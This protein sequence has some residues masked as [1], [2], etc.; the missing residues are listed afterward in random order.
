M[1]PANNY[2]KFEREWTEHSIPECYARRASAYANRVAVKTIARELTYRD[3]D[4]ISNGVA[5]SILSLR[6]R[7][8]EPVAILLEHDA[9]VPA[10]ILGVLKAGKFYVPLD[11]SYPLERNRFILDDSQ[12]KLV[13]TNS[14]N[15]SLATLLCGDHCQLVNLD[16]IES[17]CAD[18]FPKSQLVADDLVYILY[19]SGST[20]KPKGVMHTHRSLLHNVM[21]Q[22]NGRRICADDRIALLFSYSFGPSAVNTF[23][24]LLNGATLLPFNL[25]E[26]GVTRLA[27]WLT[28]R[29]ITQFHTVPTVFRHFVETLAE[30]QRFPKLR[31][32][33]LGGETIHQKDVALFK[34]HFGDHCI[35]HVGMGTGESGLVLESFYDRWTECNADPIPA[36]YVVEDTQVLLLD[37]QGQPVGPGDI[38]EIA[39]KNRFLSPGYWRNPELTRAVF[40]PDPDG[41]SERIYLTGDQ[42]YMLPDGCVV[43]VGRKDFQVKIRGYRVEIG[44]VEAALLGVTGVKEAVVI[45]WDNPPDDKRLVAYVVLNVESSLTTRA[46]HSSLKKKLPSYMVPSAIMRLESLPLL[47]NGKVDRKAL[48]APDYSR[49]ELDVC[50]IAPRT[51]VEEIV[52]GIWTEVLKVP[53][54]GVEED[55]FELGGHSLLATQVVSRMA[56]AFQINLPLN[57]LFEFP[58]V[59]ALARKVETAL[60]RQADQHL[61]TLCRMPREGHLMLSFGQE[62]LWFLDQ[63]DPGRSVYNVPWVS[64]LRG[65]LNVEAL[66]SALG[67]VV[68]RHEVLRTRYALMEGQP[69]QV[70]EERGCFPLRH[71]DLRDWPEEKREPEVERLVMEEASRAFDLTQ[72]LM[73]RALLIREKE[74]HWVLVLVT[75]HIASDAWSHGI[76][77]RELGQ[78]YDA[79]CQGR[80]AEMEEL[81]IQYTDYA[82]WQRQWLSGEVLEQQLSYWKRQ[83]GEESPVLELPYDRPRRTALGSRGGRVRF[84]L[85]A[86][87]SRQLRDL[88]R[89]EGVT[90]F[91]TLL[92][93]FQVLLYRYTGQTDL[94]LGTPIAGRT[95]RELEGLIGFFVNTLVLRT[96]VEGRLN[97][98]QLLERVREVALGAYS[99]QELP[100][101]RLVQELQPERDL[102][103]NPLF[104]VMFALRN[105]PG[106]RLDL[107]GVEVS[108]LEVEP[109]TAAFDLML[110]VRDGEEQLAGEVDYNAELFDVGTMQRLTGHYRR[111]LE[112]IVAGGVEQEIW[113]LSLL[114]ETE[115][116]QLLVEWNR[117][118]RD[119]PVGNSL[120]ELFEQQ[121]AER[122]ESLAV[123]FKGESW[124][125]RQL[126]ERA[127]R[128]AQHLVELGVGL[129]ERV[130]LCLDRSPWMVAGMIGTLKAGGA[131]VPLDPNYP[132]E[133]L[134]FMLADAQVRVLVTQEHLIEGL[135]LDQVQVVCLDPSWET[136]TQASQANPV[137]RATVRNLAYL[138]YTSGTTGKPKGV[139]N[140]QQGAVNRFQWMWGTYPFEA[141]EICCQKTSLSF[142]DSEWEIFGPLLQGV[143]LILIPDEDVKDTYRLVQSLAVHNVTRIV[144]VPS[145]LASILESHPDLQSRLP[146]LKFWISSGEA[147]SAE[148]FERFRQNM[149]GAV[150]LN[151]YGSSEVS[152]DATWYDTSRNHSH[153][154]IPIGRPIANTQIYVLDQDMQPVPIGVPGEVH[155]GGAGLARGYHNRPGLTAEQF[156]PNPYSRDPGARL[157]KTGD[158]G[159]YRQDGN[160]E[161]QGRIDRQVKIRGYRIELGEIEAVL[162]G[163]PEVRAAAVAVQDEGEHRRLVAY[164]VGEFKPVPSTAELYSFLRSKLPEYMVPS[165]YMELEE[166]PLTPN[167]KVD[168]R[169][170]PVPGQSRPSLEHAFT[171]PRTPVEELLA[172]I[173]SE[174][175][176]L[177]TVGVCDSFFDLGGHSLLAVQVITRMRKTFQ[178]EI[179]L[180]ALFETPTIE[181]LAV[182]VV[183]MLA[184]KLDPGEI[185]DLTPLT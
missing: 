12:S 108:R 120:V 80:S 185:A 132:Q 15:L 167:G 95:R 99:H 126:N 86:E 53:Q 77:S 43:H 107:E 105:T 140:L 162:E 82:L 168:R 23:C 111:L 174:V 136:S 1:G 175:L 21:R 155:I 32:I 159:R 117:T 138:I 145:L 114:T 49:S 59:A 10:A 100:F 62:R 70:V 112:E 173:W 142:V 18:D 164:V 5:G 92:A 19:T 4:S 27:E 17:R 69:V 72:D 113:R 157:Y 38:G 121:A 122:P 102:S 183:G 135:P 29:E 34:Q 54:L 106:E 75:H 144:S 67:Q 26:L 41:G 16:E 30:G 151:L 172:G 81:P 25:K 160:I 56:K 74:A 177:E 22:T 124:N 170:L 36:G 129:E 127:N 104:Q 180:R 146:R 90:L 110:S 24:A 79:F 39:I 97:F 60:Q 71:V 103:R 87:L 51:P 94:V 14:A 91:M 98:H 48:P 20:G 33:R 61:L 133:R 115:Q 130:G 109:G 184:E 2:I 6:G 153:A 156:V 45:A 42:G 50:F 123:V 148:L 89:R 35:L 169:A 64:R 143:P 46:L 152:A 66:E 166:L 31:L 119:Y 176:K 65:M 118:E 134:A 9:A 68:Q 137:C 93:T 58:T 150:L 3:L 158:L 163:H 44:E 171:S 83:L 181:G 165:V 154:G 63:L 37:E 139:L 141:G 101:E 40:L 8:A 78:F 85:P 128:L 147:L 96:Q 149:P 131:Y 55:F 116:Q 179:S 161:Y 73:L 76:L 7:H 47:P 52:T 178:L 88:S 84:E 182:T 28:D 57:L 11:P 125:Y 13:I